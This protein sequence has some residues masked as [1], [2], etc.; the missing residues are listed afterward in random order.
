MIEIDNYNEY[1]ETDNCSLDFYEQ[2]STAI[3]F[4]K[5]MSDETSGNS[6][7]SDESED[8]WWN[9]EQKNNSQNELEK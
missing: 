5:K 2:R 8:L 1:P 6:V 9:L 7:M 3:E 4:N